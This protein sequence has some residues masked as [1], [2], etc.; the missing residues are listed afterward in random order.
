[1]LFKTNNNLKQNKMQTFKNL[2]LQVK[3]LIVTATILTSLFSFM[4]LT[5]G[6]NSF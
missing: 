4:V 6:F 5:Q 2:D 1:M 3:A